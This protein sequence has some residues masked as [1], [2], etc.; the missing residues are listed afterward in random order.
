MDNPNEKP[1]IPESSIIITFAAPGSVHLNINFK[2]VTSL[3]AVAA[4]WY[5]SKQA[6]AGF[7]QEQMQQQEAVERNKIAVPSLGVRKPVPK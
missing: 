6:E 5:I 7:F 1:V 3:Q 4:A 2:N